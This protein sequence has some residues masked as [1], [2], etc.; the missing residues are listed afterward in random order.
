M[1][2]NGKAEPTGGGRDHMG[3]G[4]GQQGSGDCLQKGLECLEVAEPKR[5]VADMPGQVSFSKKK[6]AELS[7]QEWD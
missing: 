1:G 3:T 5:G 6:A 7:G 4:R 2:A